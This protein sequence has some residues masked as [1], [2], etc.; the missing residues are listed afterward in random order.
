MWTKAK[1]IEERLET[2]DVRPYVFVRSENRIARPGTRHVLD[3]FPWAPLYKDPLR[4]DQLEFAEQILHLENAA[5]HTSAM[6]MPRWVFYDCAVMPGFVAGFAMKTEKVPAA[7]A[8]VLRVSQHS[9]WTPI[10]LFIIIPTMKTGEWVAHNLCAVNSLV[11]EVERMYG[12]GFLTKAFSLWYAN[13]ETCCGMTQW[14]N[15]ALKLHT[16][17]GHLQVL[18]AYTPVHSHA[19]TITYR[20]EVRAQSWEAFFTREPDHSFALNFVNSGLNVDAQSL[21][22]MQSLQTRIE[23]GEGPFFLSAEEL[24]SGVAP[25]SLFR[26]RN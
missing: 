6:P 17:F 1:W 12:L 25:L 13:V 3:W 4:L 8:K 14:G 5:F 24:A 11:P 21:A 16:H 20:S 19:R 23:A 15:A 22:S 2:G 7:F 9:E 10:S 18:T 26:R